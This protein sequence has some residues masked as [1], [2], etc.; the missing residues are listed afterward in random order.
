[1]SVNCSPVLK[2]RPPLPAAAETKAEEKGARQRRLVRACIGKLVSDRVLADDLTQDTLARIQRSR[3]SHRGD[4]SERTWLCAIAHNVVRDHFRSAAKQ[5]RISNDPTDLERQASDEDIEKTLMK[6]E[7]SSCIAEL[8]ARLPKKQGDVVAFYDMIGLC[9][10]EIAAALGISVENS[11][12]LLHRGRN[13][14]KTLLE[15]N[16]HLSIGKGE[17]CCERRE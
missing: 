15:A 13:A 7:M 8:I 6:A 16:C 4:A 3:T 2:N 17:I 12:V 5:P 11:R 14:L 10:E 1:M 9:H